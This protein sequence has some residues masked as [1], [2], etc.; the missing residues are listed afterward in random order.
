M[1]TDLCG[2]GAKELPRARTV[3]EAAKNGFEFYK[4]IQSEDGHW[5]GAY[6]GTPLLS[7]PSLS[8]ANPSSPGIGPLFLIPG[9]VI[10]L[11][12][13]H[14]TLRPE[15][16][17]EIIRYLLHKRKPEGGWGLCVLFSALP[18]SSRSS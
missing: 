15:Q 9:L 11:Y 12:V 2:K 3:E 17:T 18:S 5:A 1:E 7:L 13:T 8:H 10:G 14:T 4:Q 6:G 16:K